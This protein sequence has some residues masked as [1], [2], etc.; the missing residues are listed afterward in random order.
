MKPFDLTPDPRVLLALTHTAMKPIDALCELVD[1]AIDSLWTPGFETNGS[2]E[3]NIDLPTIGELNSGTGAIRVADNGPGMGAESAE[4]ALT[5]GYSGKNAYD[6]LGMFGMG[7]NIATGKFARATRLITATKNAEAAIL[8]NV[9]LWQLMRQKHYQVQPE[10]IDRSGYF[11]KGESGTIIELS[12]WWDAGSVNRDFPKKLVQLGPGKIREAL[13]RRYATLLRGDGPNP[14]IKI[15]VKGE[16]CT[17]FEHCVWGKDRFVTKGSSRYHALKPFNEVL[18]TQTRCIECDQPVEGSVCP[19]DETHEVRPVEERVRGWIG[20]QRYDD[21]SHFGVDLI[22]NGRA[23]RILEKAA[24]FTFTNEA[25]E[26][27]VDYPVDSTYGRIVGEVHLDHVRVDFA[28][29]DFNRTTPEWQRAVEYLRGKSSLKARSQGAD[30]NHSPVME[31]FRGYRR[32]R[33]FGFGDMYMGVREPNEEKASR[34]GRDVEEEF[35]KKF[36]DREDG[37]YDDAKWWEKVEEAS[38]PPDM[39]AEECP[40]CQYQ[41]HPSAEVCG[42][43]GA[44][45]LSKKCANPDCGKEIPRSAQACDHCGKSQIPEGP[46]KCGVCGHKNN[47][48]DAEECRKCGKPKGAV[49][50]FAKE[51][52]LANSS[53]DGSLS[54]QRL[55]ILL[56]DGSKSE[57]FRL[58][59]RIAK[60]RSEGISLPSVV[61]TDMSE[62][63]LLVFLDKEHPMFSSLQLR[64]EHAVAAEAAAF[65]RSETAGIMSGAYR[66]QHNLLSLQ[67]KVLDKYWRAQLL[68]SPQEIQQSI[69]ALLEDV[70]AKMAETMNDIAEDVFNNM[71][72][73]EKAAMVRNMEEAGVDI[74]QM[75][76][77]KESGNF[78][79]YVPP[80]TVISVFREYPERFFDRKVWMPPW[81]IPGGLPEENVRDVQ[82]RIKDSYLNSLEDVVRFL[83]SRNPQQ[84][85]SRRAKLSLQVLRREMVD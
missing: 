78:M 33:E 53:A 74:S 13:G 39:G 32:V 7:L 43:C 57:V 58:E 23:I 64:L 28:K 15:F 71:S 21:L 4:K 40:E 79:L 76:K 22:R 54:E 65:I 62:R 25:G 34:I 9:D 20:V 83:R 56:P 60:L 41:N 48:P 45:L 69:R 52:L 6:R 68:D 38:A 12:E 80:E 70:C 84:V 81:N 47:P 50:S 30:E 73:H 59:T 77:L 8:V 16:S 67:G 35:Y 17:P 11:R 26:E 42:G 10:E 72:S 85:F 31:I 49:N 19:E 66:D 18:W 75:D 2:R 14:A 3:I 63:K 29:Q 44:L 51:I 27:S 36:L 5:A 24:F 1:N 37:Y 61:F 82:K 55:E 46:W